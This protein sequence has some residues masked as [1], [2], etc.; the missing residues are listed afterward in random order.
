MNSRDRMSLALSHKEADRIPVD[1]SSRS[2][3]IEEEAYNDLK[4]YLGIDR[5]TELFIRSHAEPDEEVLEKF[6]VD[7]RYVRDI[8][9]E[10]W[11]KSNGE[12]IFTDQWGVRWKRKKGSFYYD[13]ASFIHSEITVDDIDKIKWPALLTD[14]S[15]EAMAKK[16]AEL[17]YQTDKCLFTDVLGA[18][19]FESA[20]YMRGFENFMMDMAIDEK[21][22]HAYLN[23]I[24]EL[25]TSAYE[26]LLN[27]IG[28]YIQG[29]LITDDLAMQDGLLM[30]PEMYR[31]TLKPYQKRLY[32]FI[33]SK[34]VTVIYH[35]CGAIYPLID[36]LLEIGV[37]VLHP[38]QLSAKGMDASKLK[39]E[40]GD[41]IVFWGGG[42][43]T[44]KT[45]QFGTP[46]EV[47]EE[48]KS[49]I[50]ILAPGGGYVFAPEHC[51]Q[52]G[53][54]PENIIALFEALEEY[55]RYK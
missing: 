5:P 14:E 28:K 11:N 12:Y 53:T 23:K 16:A 18:G 20:W 17:Y 8:P 30:S 10:S 48:V 22:T 9:P 19:I 37:R 33:Q 27:A 40:Y 46:M 44:Q 4:N 31:K 39:K 52:P 45:L 47:R 1:L 55:G 29:V 13:I 35:T 2:S 25:Q 38:V 51:I 26:K 43:N 49:R 50:S 21:F 6:N 32:E 42:C 34:G 7:T 3:A 41:R 15:V 36:D 54:P 24:L